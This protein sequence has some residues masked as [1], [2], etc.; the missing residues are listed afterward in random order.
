MTRRLEDL[1]AASARRW[2]DRVA[3]VDGARSATYLEVADRADA[4]ATRLVGLGCRPGD[5]VVIAAP[6]S[7]DAIVAMHAVLAADAAYVPLDLDSPPA[8][9]RKVLRSCRPSAVLASG[10]FRGPV[11]EEIAAASAETGAPVAWMDDRADPPA[12]FERALRPE[13]RRLAGH[14]APA[15]EARTAE[16][17]HILFT[18]GSTGTPKGVMIPHASV[19]AFTDWAN[20]YFRAA[21]GERYSGHSPLFFD[22]STWDIYG[23]L[24][25]G[26]ELHLVPAALNL[27]AAR[28]AEFIRERRLARW[29]SVPS[30]L[31]YMAGFDV[32]GQ[33]DFPELREL[34]WCG[35]VFP[36]PALRH[37]MARLPHV[38]FTNLYG[39]TEATIASSVHTVEA[40]PA[41]DTE[42]VPI[43]VPC[44]G[45]SLHVVDEAL[46]D[47]P[48]GT[49]GELCISGAGL[50]VGYWNDPV[51]TAAA[52][53]T[54]P[55]GRRLYRTGDLACVG[56]DA[57]VR[58]RGRADQQIKSRGYRIELGEIEAA[59]AQLPVLAEAAVVAVP[60]GGF[61]GS[62]IC[63]AAVPAEGEDAEPADLSR[64]LRAHV[65]SYMVPAEWMLLDRLPRT[66]N[67]KI[68][69]KDI[70]ERFSARLEA[71]GLGSPAE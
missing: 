28:L 71:R 26:A 7:I 1:L 6:K 17:A 37:W 14:R 23:S 10:S 41:S 29:F 9:I 65:P 62:R 27:I 15:R 8:R 45:E 18:S 4:W 2:P 30:I 34:V 60:T 42:D 39:P 19:L 67:N 48:D 56:D 32:V 53:V 66:G 44:G 20:A 49:V 52:F 64:A 38:R 25:C 21:P 47:V 40:I 63:C 22:L 16:V 58:F 69:R 5:R 70:R 57:L 36:T 55:D 51:R 12:A 13:D 46:R 24:A 3:I 50:A 68:D 33:D 31:T 11:A 61:E 54:R 43:G 59:L 35:E